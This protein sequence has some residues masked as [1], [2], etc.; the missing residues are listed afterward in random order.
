L[1]FAPGNAD[2]ETIERLRRGRFVIIHDAMSP[3][4]RQAVAEALEPHTSI[5]PPVGIRPKY[6]AGLWQFAAQLQA[7]VVDDAIAKSADLRP[8]FA[9]FSLSPIPLVIHLGFLLSDRVEVEAFQYDRERN[10]WRWDDGLAQDADLEI[11]TRG[12]PDDAI[13][14]PGDVVVRVSLSDIIRPRDTRVHVPTPLA[15]IDITVADPDRMW[16]RSRE[17]LVRLGREFR[18]VLKLIGQ[19]CP[20]VSRIHLFV[21]APT[22]ACIEL[23]R[24]INPRMTPPVELYEFDWQKS[25]RYE[26][27]LTLGIEGARAPGGE[28]TAPMADGRPL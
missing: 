5:G 19:R 14:E 13:A 28:V 12:V 17:Q 10:S 8:R 24:A 16:L 21:C 9:V 7:A 15:E 6:G 18:R 3:I 2:P 1:F 22:P 20:E 4:D 25:P 26:H 27:V 11:G 23:G